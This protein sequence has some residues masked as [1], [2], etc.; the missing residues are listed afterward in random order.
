MNLDNER[1]GTIPVMKAQGTS[2]RLMVIG[3]LVDSYLFD[4]CQE[5]TREGPAGK[6]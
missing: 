1:A 3:R 2:A 5:S 4:P 6:L